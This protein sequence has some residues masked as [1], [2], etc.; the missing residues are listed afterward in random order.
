MVS[1]VIGKL[2]K[3]WVVKF[4]FLTF[5]A[6]TI[7]LYSV[8]IQTISDKKLFI[9]LLIFPAILSLLI[10]KF[11]QKIFLTILVLSLSLAA[12]FRFGNMTF[13]TGGAELSIAPIDFALLGLI[14]LTIANQYGNK[15]KLT[16]N[17]TFIEKAFL[18][19]LLVHFLSIYFAPD[20]QL[21]FLEFFR[22]IKMGVM[23]LMIKIY[24]R[25]EREI[26]Y[27]VYLLLLSIIFQAVLAVAQARFN[28]SL[29]L[30]FLGERDSILE[31]SSASL[32][33]NRA[34]GTMGHSN[35]LGHF[36]ELFLPI[37]LA[38]YLNRIQPKSLALVAYVFGLIG[39]FFTFSRGAWISVVA[40]TLLVV[41]FST[42]WFKGRR[43]KRILL[44][45]PFIVILI[46]LVSFFF[47][48]LIIQRIVQ[49]GANSWIFRLR[50]YQVAFNM[51]REHPIIGVGANNYLVV[52]H[53][54]G[55]EIISSSVEGIAHNIFLLITAELGLLGLTAFLIL[56]IS[57][58]K[59]AKH[60]IRISSAFGKAL[61][62]GIWAGLISFFLHSMLGWLFRYD[63]IHT[64]F[65]FNVGL[66]IAIENTFSRQE[67]D[68]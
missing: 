14:F 56:L 22:L 41:I 58:N 57:I 53:L 15:P 60:L 12:R 17:V 23:I 47:K 21:A 66:L 59:Q 65:W 62:I 49:F 54:Y 4:S 37:S 50:T 51:I 19:Y 43:R 34:G 42:T 63:P 16:L 2:D 8:F 68:D 61:T 30:G 7:G 55:Q 36:F 46:V 10:N 45:S 26:K 48:D 32:R 25:T 40:G 64:I 3:K 29:G 27:I 28:T 39:V 31:V 11:N 18:L 67:P 33:L 1:R 35:A 13:H 9:V 52:A 24:F 6:V 20:F 5:L 44:Y 38:L